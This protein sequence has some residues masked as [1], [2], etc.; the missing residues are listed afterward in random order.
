MT[1][2]PVLAIPNFKE[3]FI[4]ETNASGM[5]I[6]VVL[7]QGHHPIA[8]FSKKWSAR[9][10]HQSAYIREFYAITETIAKSRHYVLGHKFIIKTDHQSLKVLLEQNLQIPE[11]QQWLPKFLGCDFTIQYK[12][13]RENIPPMRYL[14]AW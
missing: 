12:P 8:Y 4:L 7:Y 6:G 3:P 10:Q 14:E 5:G 1:S 11:Q 9:M 13:G 2:T